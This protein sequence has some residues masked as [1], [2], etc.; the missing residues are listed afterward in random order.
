MQT[1]ASLQIYV[2]TEVREGRPWSKNDPYVQ[3][4]V[5]LN[6]D[7]VL[8]GGGPRD[9]KMGVVVC[10]RSKRRSGFPSL[11]VLVILTSP[12]PLEVGTTCEHIRT[13]V[14]IPSPIGM[15]SNHGYM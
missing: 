14:R 13:G 5:S 6:T 12:V 2:R 10:E 8:S 7:I 9:L 3:I 4:G 1:S 11:S 15:H